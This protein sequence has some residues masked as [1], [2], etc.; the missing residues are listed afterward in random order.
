MREEWTSQP[1]GENRM[2]TKK[3]VSVEGHRFGFCQGLRTKWACEHFRE[4]DN[5][6]FS[7]WWVGSDCSSRRGLIQ[8]LIHDI[9]HE[10]IWETQSFKDTLPNILHSAL[11]NKRI[12][13]TG[14]CLLNYKWDLTSIIYF[15]LFMI[16]SLF[17]SV[18]LL[19]HVPLFVTHQASLS[20][21]NSW[22]LLKLMSIEPVMLSNHLILCHPLL[23]LPSIFP[24][25]GLFSIESVLHIRWP[26]YLGVSASESVLPMNIQDWFPLGLTGWICL[27]PRGLSRVFTTTV[28]KHQFF[29]IQLSL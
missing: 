23:L 16:V 28:Q 13:F 2:K 10:K 6:R 20:I 5:S 27:Q 12:V 14:S 7:N 25:I 15:V 21:T 11:E 4:R 9:L 17:S 19:S 1:Q 18:Q 22:S 26:E 24:S 8:D 29:C 3:S